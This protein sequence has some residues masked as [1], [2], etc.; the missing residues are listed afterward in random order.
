MQE[1]K[2]ITDKTYEHN[3]SRQ[4]SLFVRVRDDTQK[5][6]NKF[7]LKSN[8]YQSQKDLSGADYKNAQTFKTKTKALRTLKTKQSQ[9]NR[10]FNGTKRL[11]LTNNASSTQKQDLFVESS[12]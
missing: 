3:Q 1:S 12:V 9:K 4:V 5:F 6:R 11:R 10:L 2:K 8:S 7:L